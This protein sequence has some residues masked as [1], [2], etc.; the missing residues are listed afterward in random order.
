[1]ETTWQQQRREKVNKDDKAYTSFVKNGE[2][3]SWGELVSSFN[4]ALD[5]LEKHH[6][7]WF[8]QMEKCRELKENLNDTEVV[9][10]INFSENCGLKLSTEIWSFHFGGS[11]K[12]ATIHTCVVYT[13]QG[14]KS[15]AAISAYVMMKELSG[16][17]LNQS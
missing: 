2:T 14:C 17:T 15:Y 3:G 13:K 9:V 7:N 6:F 10:H 16:H 12:Q 4:E 5:M 11:R 1:M 8:H